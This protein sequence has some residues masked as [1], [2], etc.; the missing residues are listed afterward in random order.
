MKSKILLIYTMLTISFTATAHAKE[1]QPTSQTLL[2]N[3]ESVSQPVY[4]ID[5]NNYFRLR[6]LA[7]ELNFGCTYN[8]TNN[9]IELDTS[10]PYTDDAPKSIENLTKEHAQ[11]SS[12][13][14]YLNGNLCDIK[15]YN[16]NGNNYFKVR[17]LAKAVN[18]GCIYNSSVNGIE[19]DNK[20]EYS[21]GDV[22]GASKLMGEMSVH[23]LDVGQ[24]D[25]IFIELPDGRTMLIDAST[26]KFG[27]RICEYIKNKSYS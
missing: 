23:F 22:F 9:S 10:S 6:D 15:A 14:V 21:E 4:N 19:I 16:I 17:D 12:Q 25:S 18:F 8:G 20:Y 26:G 5:G 7:Y 2:I 24:G 3:G 27:D 1:A 13:T 11:N